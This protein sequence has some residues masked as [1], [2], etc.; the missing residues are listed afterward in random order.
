M[1]LYISRL[2]IF[3]AVLESSV[4]SNGNEVES[5]K[6]T[7]WHF[8]PKSLNS[9][10]GLH[11]FL[12]IKNRSWSRSQV[13]F[14]RARSIMPSWPRAEHPIMPVA[15]Q[16]ICGAHT[17]SFRWHWQPLPC[18]PIIKARRVW[19]M[20]LLSAYPNPASRRTLSVCWR[21]DAGRT[22]WRWRSP[23]FPTRL[24]PGRQILSW[25]SRRVRKKRLPLQK[26]IRPNS[27]PLPCFPRLWGIQRN[28]GLSLTGSRAGS[29]RLWHSMSRLCKWHSA[30]GIWINVS[31]LD[32]DSIMQRRS[33]GPWRWK[34][35]RIWSP[36]PIPR[37]ISSMDRSRWWRVDSLSWLLHRRARF[38]GPWPICW[39]GCEGKRMPSWLSFRM[40]RRRWVLP[41]RRSCFRRTSL[42]GSVRWWALSLLNCSPVT[43]RR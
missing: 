5:V 21:K 20:H 43:W 40:M 41:S 42:S 9:R 3:H 7:T 19:R 2:C 22:V 36:S 29:N 26:P 32:G 1:S 28:A 6:R 12:R 25:I 27:W 35:W 15:M 18:L 11:P 13:R 16:T 38:T 17:T 37:P 10:C 31:C 33:S 30:T 39:P 4:E 8:I 14:D 24:W 23:T 34:S